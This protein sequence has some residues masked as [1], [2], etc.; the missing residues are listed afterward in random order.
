M[1]FLKS[2]TL[3]ITQYNSL[4]ICRLRHSFALRDY[5]EEA[6]SEVLAA[7][8][9]GIKRQAVVMATG[10]G[11]T[12][13][14]S[15]LIP[16]LKG[17]KGNKTLVLAHTQELISQSRE[18]ISKINPGLKV[19]VEMGK[20]RSD[21][22][23]DVIVASVS[24]LVRLNRFEKFNPDDFKTIIIDECHHAVA[25]SYRK[26][27]DYFK[28]SD[29][30]TEIN[31]IGLTA[32]LLR[33]DN[34]K[35]GLVF[36]EVVYE[37]ELK[38]MIGKGEL[39]DFKISNARIE[40]FNLS[41]I[42]KGKDDYDSTSLY[43]AL[44]DVDINEKIL[45]SYMKMKENG[46][47]NSTL[48]FC[49]TVQHCYELCGL[50]QSHGINAQY[51]TAETTKVSRKQIVD[52][53]KNRKIPVLCNVGVLAEGADIPN[54]D[55]I[56]LSRP[57]L[58]KTLKVQMIGRGLRNHPGKTHCHVVDL[59][60]LTEYGL[61]IKSSLRGIDPIDSLTKSLK[62]EVEEEEEDMSEEEAELARIKSLRTIE[63]RRKHVIKRV[64][65]YHKNG[66][67]SFTTVN[68]LNIFND[69]LLDVEV[70]KGILM[71]GPH[72]WVLLKDGRNAWGFGIGTK[73]FLWGLSIN[74]DEY[75]LISMTSNNRQPVFVLSHNHFSNAGLK[76][77]NNL[78][79]EVIY[80]DILKVLDIFKVKYPKQLEK[81]M[82]SKRFARRA[83]ENQVSFI[84]KCL[85]EKIMVECKIRSHDID[86]FTAL[87][88]SNIQKEPYVLISNWIFALKFSK[89]SFYAVA[90]SRKILAKTEKQYHG[91]P[92]DPKF[93]A[94]TSY[95]SKTKLY[96]KLNA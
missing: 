51:V 44:S 49:V 88:K 48:I 14:F 29:K 66:V 65:E 33:R 47:Y 42:K 96:A 71:K 5:Q 86:K 8:E 3:R 35:L 26:I 32:T 45:L 52:D 74:I 78:E 38:D 17:T 12:V 36:D 2:I 67:M 31:V 91:Q 9:R 39:C 63:E 20:I 10:G 69:Y 11:K 30:T 16:L 19:G 57:T 55:S 62:D 27:L 77:S 25:A 56:I 4:P 95:S 41:N 22:N 70:I 28:A 83:N 93:K 87:V 61:H 15:H 72:P 46:S 59:V 1:L 75:F 18:K 60:G 43:S 90:K 68:G 13:I 37:R 92:V 53:F 50:F 73:E 79:S 23:D 58:S 21:E 54:I 76:K 40:N 24:S 7:S 84:L 85:K 82:T 80:G 6:I 81:A 64:L 89:A 94:G 34:I